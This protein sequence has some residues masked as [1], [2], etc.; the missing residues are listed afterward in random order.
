M[1]LPDALLAAFDPDAPSAHDTLF[2]LPVTADQCAVQLIG[3]PWEATTSYGRGTRN[4][5][6]AILEASGQVDL[7]DLDFGE[8][9]RHGVGLHPIDPDFAR[10]GD[11][12]E[13]DAQAVIASG[14]QDPDAAARVNALSEAV[15]ERVYQHACKVLDAGAIPAVLGGDH[16]TPFGL[17]RAVTERFP[18]VGY[19]HIDAHADLRQAYEG[20]TH[21][22]A[23]VFYNVHQL[24]KAGVHVG[25]GWRDVGRGERAF[26]AAHPDKVRAFFDRDIGMALAGGAT[27]EA[28]VAQ[29]IDALPPQVH[30]S[31]DIDGLDPSLCPHTGTPVPGGLSFFQV[32]LLLLR[33]SQ[34]RKI[35]SFD[36]N[37]VAPGP[38][39]DEWDANVGARILYKLAGAALRSQGLVD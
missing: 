32:Q 11:E 30:V 34:R 24:P 8:L 4:G 7:C 15:N 3:V 10:W 26:I 38:D 17:I 2:G 9:W 14:G 29:I 27:W 23:S 25:V 31:F 21:S 5:P 1:P 28:V 39:G 35:V 6:A 36:L 22:H 18:G 19:L 13:E 20:F 37:E 16:S 12:A 33:L